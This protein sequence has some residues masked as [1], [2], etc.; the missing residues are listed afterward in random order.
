MEE[1]EK[2]FISFLGDI[3]AI[4]CINLGHYLQYIVFFLDIL[5]SIIVKDISLS[6]KY[7]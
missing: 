5:L 7:A 1:T 6:Y 3:I 2:S 4:F